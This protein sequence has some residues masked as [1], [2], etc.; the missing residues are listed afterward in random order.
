MIDPNYKDAWN[1]KGV[2]LDDQGKYEEAIECYERALEIDPNDKD[3]WN[4]KGVA[5]RKQGKYE[6]AIE[7][8]ER[9]LEIDP[10]DKDVIKN[11][12]YLLYQI[13]KDEKIKE[14]IKRVEKSI[15]DGEIYE[16]INDYKKLKKLGSVIPKEIINE[17]FKDLPN[18]LELCS[19][20][21]KLREM[22]KNKIKAESM[23]YET[24]IPLEEIYNIDFEELGLTINNRNEIIK[25]SIKSLIIDK[26]INAKIV[27]KENILKLNDQIRYSSMVSKKEDKNIEVKRKLKIVNDHFEFYVKIE[28]LDNVL[29]LNNV[30]VHLILPNSLKERSG[31]KLVELGRILSN[32][33][34]TAKFI[35][36]CSAICKKGDVINANILYYD[37]S[38]DLINIKMEP[39][40]IDRCVY[41][42]GVELTETKIKD[43]K[44]KIP[45]KITYD[46]PDITIE[47]IRN[48]IEKEI[49]LKSIEVNSSQIQFMGKTLDDEPILV[50][51]SKDK[52]SLDRFF[53]KIYGKKENQ[54]GIG[55]ILLCILHE[56]YN[57][58]EMEAEALIG[59]EKLSDGLAYLVTLT[60]DTYDQVKINRNIV[61]LIKENASEKVL[62]R[63]FRN[64]EKLVRKEYLKEDQVKPILENF[65]KALEQHILLGKLLDKTKWG[66][67]LDYLKKSFKILLENAF[68]AVIGGVADKLIKLIESAIN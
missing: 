23:V 65:T 63:V 22:V 24:E 62:K 41:T 53:L 7:C 49:D 11:K 17:E 58:K 34:A 47:E 45:E 66:K 30:V 3:A 68:G 25:K 61:Y 15:S 18:I 31:K 40:P 64:I 9:A 59:I 1:N 56:L 50:D 10:N 42:E 36:E 48:K 32:K 46:L 54:I 21:I 60:N 37:K 43:L 19:K 57:I 20:M 38:G 39:Y 35:I 12:E 27:I 29:A 14:L 44:G 6:E 2:A 51:V 13:K 28:N 16:R 67:F 33:Y 8:Y 52:N 26:K 55:E 4:N 5:L